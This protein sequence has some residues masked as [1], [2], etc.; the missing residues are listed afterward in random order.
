MSSR[1]GVAESFTVTLEEIGQ[2]LSPVAAATS[3]CTTCHLIACTKGVYKHM[4]SI[5]E[6]VANQQNAQINTG[7]RSATGK[8]QSSK[9]PV[10]NGL[11]AKPALL[12]GENLADY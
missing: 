2:A 11:T 7:P 9:K 12:P 6:I 8:S 4:V 1:P 5:R 3:L 10:K